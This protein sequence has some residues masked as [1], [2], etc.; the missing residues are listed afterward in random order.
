MSADGVVEGGADREG[1]DTVVRQFLQAFP[2]LV[3]PFLQI[4]LDLG[5][6]IGFDH[7]LGVE[8]H[9]AAAARQI[10]MLLA[11]LIGETCT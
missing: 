11:R 6:L 9:E 4:L 2:L 3:H 1:A 10:R 5:A 8:D 7:E